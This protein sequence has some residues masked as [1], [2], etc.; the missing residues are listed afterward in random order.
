[1]RA[2]GP[3]EALEHRQ[4][5]ADLHLLHEQR[6]LDA[7]GNLDVELL[8]QVLGGEVFERQMQPFDGAL[9]DVEDVVDGHAIG[10]RLQPAPKVELREPRDDANE[11]FLR[12]ILSDRAT[13]GGVVIDGTE[14]IEPGLERAMV[15]QA[16]C[17]LPWL[18]GKQ[19]VRLAAAQRRQ[20]SRTAASADD[21][22]ELV[23][24][25]DAASQLPGQMSSE[26]NSAWHSRVRCRSSRAF[27]SST[28]RSRCSTR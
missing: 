28:S 20:P 11:D 21:Y 12:R 17:L 6:V 19:N 7:R 9:L 16:P 5:A 23:G 13:Y 3:I 26:L 1:M 2:D 25:A 18:T 24:V 14:V 10:P 15:F 27:F 4:R 22:L 8:R